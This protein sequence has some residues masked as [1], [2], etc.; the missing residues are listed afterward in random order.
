MKKLT[1][2]LKE[3]VAVEEGVMDDVGGVEPW[4][5]HDLICEDARAEADDSRLD[6]LYEA[7]DREI[8][9]DADDAWD[10]E[11]DPLEMWDE[12]PIEETPRERALVEYLRDSNWTPDNFPIVSREE[13]G[14]E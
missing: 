11:Y 6:E 12:D 1:L 7:Y 3:R 13:F 9:E 10:S 2:E 5:I 4:G 8:A 14:L